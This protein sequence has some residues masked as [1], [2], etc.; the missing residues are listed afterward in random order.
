VTFHAT[1]IAVRLRR[2]H[3]S[4]ASRRVLI[5]YLSNNIGF[6]SPHFTN[7]LITHSANPS[8]RILAYGGSQ[9]ALSIT[10]TLSR[11]TSGALAT[12]EETFA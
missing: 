7:G 5:S 9:V 4:A 3:I 2:N 8:I 11:A 12:K 6:C 1:V 10:R